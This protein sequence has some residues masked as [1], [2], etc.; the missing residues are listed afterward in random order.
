MGDPMTS[1][2]KALRALALALSVAPVAGCG[3]SRPGAPEGPPPADVVP[4]IETRRCAYVS[5]P[6]A[7]P[8]FDALTRSGTRGNIALWGRDMAPTDSVHLSIR[9][10]LEGQI[11]WVYAIQSTLTEER[12]RALE[13]LVLEALTEPGDPDWGVR[14]RVIGG[15]VAA[16]EP[17]IICPAEIIDGPYRLTGFPVT[18]A[19]RSAL[20]RARGLGFP[21]RISL[22]E[23]GWI[24]DARLLRRTGEGEADQFILEWARRL[25][26][27]PKKH[28]GIGIPT[29]VE[30]LISIPRRWW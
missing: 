4:G 24:L 28:D 12:T 10:D 29:V 16:I 21:V 11:E 22:D 3:S 15:D 27:A 20:Y 2:D 26:F 8:S 19:G 23:R 5:S 17:S 18:A 7:L 14:V 1:V 13:Q 6:D 9:Y 30:E 25:R